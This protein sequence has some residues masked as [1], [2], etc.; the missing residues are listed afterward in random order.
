MGDIKMGG[1]LLGGS[2][3]ELKKWGFEKLA[4]DPVSPFAG[5]IWENTTEGR[6]HWYDGTAV[7]QMA[8]L[9]DIAS[10]LTWKGG[11]DANTN[12]PNLDSTPGAGTIKLGDFYYVT[13]AGDFYTEA[14]QVGDALIANQDDPTA[15]T[16]WTRVQ[17]NV[18]QATESVM[19]ILKIATQVITDAGTNDTDAVTPLKLVTFLANNGYIK[20]YAVNLDNAEGTVTRVFA[21]GETTFTVVHSLGSVDI[22]PAIKEISTGDMWVTTVKTVDANTHDVV[23]NG[24]VADGVFRGTFGG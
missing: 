8:H 16:H 23:F 3:Y 12:T 18:D 14:V 17:F 11:Y 20:K 19:G 7:R 6:I 15:L 4:S 5:Q 9:G 22:L 2:G 10:A 1:H 13:V 21:G 24:N